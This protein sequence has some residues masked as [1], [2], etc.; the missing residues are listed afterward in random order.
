MINDCT[1]RCFSVSNL[2]R[3]M[4]SLI[5]PGTKVTLTG[6]LLPKSSFLPSLKTRTTFDS[7]Q[8]IETSPE[9]LSLQRLLKNNRE[10]SH[11]D[12]SQLFQYPGTN[13][14]TLHRLVCI[15]LEQQVPHKFRVSIT[16]VVSQLMAD[17]LKSPIRTR[18]FDL[19][20]SLNPLENNSS[21]S[22]SQL[23]GLNSSNRFTLNLLTLVG[24]FFPFLLSPEGKSSKSEV[25][26]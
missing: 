25:R 16:Y 14:I 11:N 17:K 2:F 9:G 15:Q 20:V 24:Q 18:A 21:A 7:F 10:T 3:P 13:P 12:I 23:G 4:F 26:I 6:L 19:E 22:P 1:F 5:L 8:F